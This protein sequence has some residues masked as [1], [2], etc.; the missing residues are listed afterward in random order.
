ME[1]PSFPLWNIYKTDNTQ[2]DVPENVNI[3]QT[4][5]LLLS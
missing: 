2:D 3:Q 1:E 5:A 4:K